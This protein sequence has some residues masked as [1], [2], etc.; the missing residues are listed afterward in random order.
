MACRKA[1][2]RMVYHK[3]FDTFITV[4]VAV[5]MICLCIEFHGAADWYIQG[6]EYANMAFVCLFTFEAIV[7]IIASGFSFYFSID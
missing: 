4:L 5:N 3:N 1:I 2:H 7:K 6:L